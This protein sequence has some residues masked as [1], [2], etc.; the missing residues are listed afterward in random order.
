MRRYSQLLLN[1]HSSLSMG[2][3]NW[4]ETISALMVIHYAQKLV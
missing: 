1:L 3:K 2:P 4:L